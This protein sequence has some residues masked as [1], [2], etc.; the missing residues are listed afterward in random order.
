M[1]PGDQHVHIYLLSSLPTHSPT[2]QD[3]PPVKLVPFS[4]TGWRLFRRSWTPAAYPSPRLY[5]A[6]R[7]SRTRVFFLSRGSA[8]RRRSQREGAPRPQAISIYR[9]CRRLARL[10]ERR[11]EEATRGVLILSATIVVKLPPVPETR[12][13]SR[14][15][16]G[17]PAIRTP[18]TC[19][20]LTTLQH[21][22]DS[23]AYI[24]VER[25]AQSA[26]R[27][28]R[29][30]RPLR[31]LIVCTTPATTSPPSSSSHRPHHA[32]IKWKPRNWRTN[33]RTKPWRPCSS[34]G[35]HQHGGWRHRLRRHPA[36]P[37]SLAAGRQ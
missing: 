32:G 4:S 30:R 9:R 7:S 20:S 27:R 21:A 31:L 28:R 14:R 35:V 24:V 11:R 25:A 3:Y 2:E 36:A 37:S 10:D 29:P 26:P 5:K 12:L 13:F 8:A 18:S 16:S 1:R 19:S 23:F 15:R 34:S 17:S 33:W 22:G 6:T